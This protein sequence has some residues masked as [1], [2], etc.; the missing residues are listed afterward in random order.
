[1]LTSP[2]EK[3]LMK[4]SSI[5][6]EKLNAATRGEFSDVPLVTFGPFEAPVYKVENKYRMRMIL[7][8]RLNRRSRAMLSEIMIKFSKANVRGLSLSVDLNPSNI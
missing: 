3:E 6:T 1:M 7:K 4:A 8:C 5:L 2:D